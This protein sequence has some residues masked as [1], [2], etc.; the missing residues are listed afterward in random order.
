MYLLCLRARNFR[1]FSDL[2][3]DW[4]R[5]LNIVYGGN[6]VGKSNIMEA[7]YI[8]ATGLPLRAQ[9]DSELAKFGEDSFYLSGRIQGER[10][11]VEVELYFKDGTKRLRL[12]GRERGLARAL[13]SIFPVVSFCPD[14]LMVLKGAPALRRHLI[15]RMI[16][17]VSKV[18]RH[19]LLAYRH[20]LAQRNAQLRLLRGRDSARDLLRPW[21]EQISQLASHLFKA[22]YHA[23]EELKVVAERTYAYLAG[24][25]EHLEIKYLPAIS[26]CVVSASASELCEFIMREHQRHVGLDLERG[27]THVGPHRDDLGITLSGVNARSFASQGQ[28]RSAV[29]ALKMAE[30]YFL[31]SR[32]GEL[33]VL[34]LDDVLSELDDRRKT[35]L[36]DWIRELEAQTFITCSQPPESLVELKPGD[37]VI[38]LGGVSM[39]R[40]E[41]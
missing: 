4:G 31:K 18:Y 35:R 3:V 21:D 8:L 2:R 40:V 10:R 12:N 17:Q 33:P 37:N 30:L 5:F 19:T 22:R 20:T 39:P 29:L 9:K 23:I 34:L 32:T 28:I 36:L 25:G 38:S 26:D 13:Y 14:D 15:D 41:I 24:M 16:S 7:I 1:G 6:A 11:L 27:F